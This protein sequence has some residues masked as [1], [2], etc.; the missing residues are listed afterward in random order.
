MDR[1]FVEATR[2]KFEE[3]TGLAGNRY[4]HEA[5]AGGALNFHLFPPPNPN[6]DG[7]DY[8]YGLF[9]EPEPEIQ[10]MWMGWQAHLNHCGGLPKV[11]DPGIRI[12]FQALANSGRL[13]S[14]YQGV[15][16]VFLLAYEGNN[17]E[18]LVD[19]IWQSPPAKL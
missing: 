11:E 19:I 1:R 3:V 15:K 17:Q 12:L 18:P 9:V 10:L 16:H 7:A 2:Q 13:Q 8:V 6:P 5:F 4:Y 14:R